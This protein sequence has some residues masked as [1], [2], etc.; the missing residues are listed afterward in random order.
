MGPVQRYFVKHPD[1]SILWPE[2]RTTACVRLTSLSEPC[3]TSCLAQYNPMVCKAVCDLGSWDLHSF[4]LVRSIPA[5]LVSLLFTEWLRH[6]LPFLFALSETFFFFFFFMPEAGLVPSLTSYSQVLA[7]LP[8][9]G[10]YLP[11][12]PSAKLQPLPT[13]L[14]PPHLA[15]FFS[16]TLVTLWLLVY[17]TLPVSSL[18][19]RKPQ[20]ISNFG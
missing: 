7:Q 6:T 13:T 4:C 17:F 20:E 16:I 15:Q 5:T 2:L 18:L 1:D 10:W 3:N 8:P 19:E 12:S 14:C 11:S 9:S